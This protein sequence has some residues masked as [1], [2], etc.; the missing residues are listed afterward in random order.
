MTIAPSGEQFEI[1][2]GRQRATIVEVGGGIRDYEV[3]GRRVLD[4]YPV[5]DMCDGA[6]GSVLV[7]WPNR[8]AD[9][10]YA[11]DGVDHQTALTEPEK[12]NA[13]HGLLRWR[14]W[15]AAQRTPDRVVMGTRLHPM[16]GYPFCLDV[17]VAYELGDDGLV[18][19]TTAT[20]VGPTS[21]PYGC[22]QHPYLSPG[23]G[24][25][26]ACTLQ[27]DAQT[28]ILTDNQRQLP[29]GTEP[30]AGTP[31]DFSQGKLL[32]NQQVDFAFTDLARDPSGRAWVHLTGL[33]GRRVELWVDEHYPIVEIYTGDTLQAQRRRQGLGTE[34]MTCPPNAFQSGEGL[35]RLEPGQS[36]TTTWGVGLKRR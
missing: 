11:F 12:A 15:R 23:T 3:A 4:P 16:I 24:L 34:P 26:D 5:D 18:V 19:A 27:L 28:R 10:R 30:V 1:T 21:C 22:G 36:L 32:G 6:H 8:L 20:N 31:F 35:L 29:T 2:S 13:I 14:S 9:G 17:S 7:P 25:I 33:D